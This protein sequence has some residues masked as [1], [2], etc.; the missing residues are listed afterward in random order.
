[1]MVTL[2]LNYDLIQTIRIT[3]A[4][5]EAGIEVGVPKE[6]A[7]KFSYLANKRFNVKYSITRGAGKPLDIEVS[8]GKPSIRIGAYEGLLLY[9]TSVFRRS[10]A[11]WGKRDQEYL[12][13]AYPT[14]ER[15]EVA[16]EWMRRTGKTPTVHMEHFERMSG[17]KKLWDRDYYA[18]IARSKFS[19]IPNGLD[20]ETPEYKD[21]ELY[22][23]TYRFIDAI[24][25]GAIPIVQNS[26][27]LYN[28]FEYYF[29]TDTDYVYDPE[30][31][32]RNFKR[33][34]KL[35]TMSNDD[36]RALL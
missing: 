24:L 9:P 11:F 5:M 36:L 25:L 14:P 8:H 13:R 16:A 19:I 28:H 27:P 26:T 32:E 33:A 31:A 29:M 30:I 4:L 18:D 21:G 10:K 23:W 3:Q 1:M 15:L 22:I 7:H 2:P 20:H 34:E 35:F 12:L 6:H 17:T